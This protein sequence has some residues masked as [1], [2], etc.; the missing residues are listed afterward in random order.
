MRRLRCPHAPV[1]PDTILLQ[2]QGIYGSGGRTRTGMQL[3]GC[4]WCDP[5]ANRHER[6]A[7]DL[8]LR[9]GATRL[10]PDKERS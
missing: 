10:A 5:P 9:R 7:R 8:L 3:L 1:V 4:P 6:R 2:A